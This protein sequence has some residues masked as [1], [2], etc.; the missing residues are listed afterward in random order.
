MTEWKT[1][2]QHHQ[3]ARC[4]RCVKKAITI[5]TATGSTG[6]T[7]TEANCF[8]KV[9]R[10][11]E[12][13]G[14]AVSTEQEWATANEVA[15]YRDKVGRIL[16]V[17]GFAANGNAELG[18]GIRGLWIDLNESQTSLVS[19]LDDS[20][21]EQAWTTFDW[22]AMV[23]G[24]HIG[25]IE[26]QVRP[27]NACMRDRNTGTYTHFDTD[28][29]LAMALAIGAL[30]DVIEHNEDGSEDAI[31]SAAAGIIIGEYDQAVQAN[32][33]D[34]HDAVRGVADDN[35]GDVWYEIRDTACEFL[36]IA[37]YTHIT[38]AFDAHLLAAQERYQQRL[39]DQLVA[40][41]KQAA[42]RPEVI[43][44]NVGRLNV[45]ALRGLL[46]GV[47]D[48]TVVLIANDGWYQETDGIAVPGEDSETNQFMC[49]TLFPGEQFDPRSL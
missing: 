35:T 3:C 6:A 33:S 11:E 16:N 1:E 47:A 10:V 43:R 38:G 17:A 7:H 44:E 39:R 22:N 40:E 4:D 36:G 15:D 28:T 18:G 29:P 45:G 14:D 26:V 25:E 21:F 42:Q 24:D 34:I 41:G 8:G 13:E 48:D 49:V 32:R 30:A 31:L 27:M 9:T 5:A 46:D 20:E 12:T 19:W 37:D 2:V 23:S